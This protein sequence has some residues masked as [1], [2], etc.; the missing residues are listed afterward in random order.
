MAHSVIT[1]IHIF[2]KRHMAVASEA[3]ATG[4]VLLQ[5]GLPRDKF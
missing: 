2:V 5:V 4:G 1:I 3:L